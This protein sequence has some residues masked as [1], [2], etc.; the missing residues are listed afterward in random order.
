MTKSRVALIH[1]IISPYRMPLFVALSNHPSIDLHVYYCA[2]RHK[3]RRWEILEGKGYRYE[4]MRGLT[5]E[6]SSFI[7]HINPVI[8][9]RILRGK[10]DFVI[11]GGDNDFTTQIALILA[12][13]K[14]I[15]VIL[16]SEG[17]EGS[18]SLL[19]RLAGPFRK[20]IARSVD[21]IIVPGTR[22][23]EYFLSMGAAPPK[24]F[25]APNIVEIGMFHARTQM[26]AKEIEDE[27]EQVFA[28]GKKVVLY[29]GQLIERKGVRYLL[30]AF[31]SLEEEDRTRFHLVI[32]GDGELRGELEKFC[33]RKEI[34]NVVF[35][36]W[37]PEEQLI[38]LYSVADVFVLPSL[39]DLCPLV[40]N[41]AMS[42]GLPV[43][44]TRAAGCSIDMVRQG[45]NGYIVQPANISE[46]FSA[47]KTILADEN[48]SRIM[49]ENSLRIIKE[50]FGVEN[51]VEG[52][53]SAIEL[54]S[55]KGN[56]NTAGRLT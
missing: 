54:A 56:L 51:A 44:T 8:I 12:K 52:F 7:Y 14:R 28:A 27:K 1:N 3:I 17:I 15:P 49:G 41:E 32:V 18:Q 55:V 11:L 16:W 21:A 23:R 46:L 53:I 24:I 31:K 37:V 36:G 38:R 2:R 20:W 39:R 22:S 4:V 40:L 26:A 43:I 48:L 34:R 5:L 19:G 13:I 35:T 25:R 47:M 33:L 50:E 30:D 9:E 29:V 42:S 6:I 10:F 45:V